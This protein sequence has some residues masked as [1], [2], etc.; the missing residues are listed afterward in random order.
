MSLKQILPFL[1]GFLFLSACS[2][3]NSRPIREA[4][5]A[6]L[7]DKHEIVS[8]GSLDYQSILN[9]AEYSKIPKVG[10]LIKERLGD[11][12]Q[13]SSPIYFAV[14][15]P[16]DSNGNPGSTVI[17]LDVKNQDTLEER[18]A[19]SGLF[20]EQDGDLKF[21]LNDDL[22]IGMK[23]NLALVVIQ[24]GDYDGKAVLKSIFQATEGEVS[25]GKTDELLQQKADVSV[26]ANLENLYG[27]S[28]T[29]LRNLN[30]TKLNEI[31][32]LV[33][34]SY[35]HA[36]LNFERGRI[37]IS[38]KNLFSKTLQKRMFLKEDPM[39][40]IR[41]KFASGKVRVGVSANL[42]VAKLEKYLDDFAPEFKQNLIQS[43]TEYALAAMVLGDSPLT[44]I[45]SGT[46]G[47]VVL[48]E[49]QLGMGGFVPEISYMV[50]I[51][52][53]GRPLFET[54]AA[55]NSNGRMSVSVTDSEMKVHS[56]GVQA[57]SNQLVVPACGAN[58]GKKGITGFIDFQGL[59]IE[60]FG[61]PTAYKSLN[62]VQNITFT[63]T[64]EGAELVI[65]TTNPKE[66][67]LKQIIDLYTRDIEKMAGN[68]V[69]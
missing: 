53:S 42:D 63:M 68:L 43:K 6:F 40:T 15:G 46:A 12:L 7:K 13:P 26:I 51:G 4:F 24:G 19:S 17:F 29:S 33:K 48:G 52:K 54:W 27:T 58:F 69:L 5:S 45:F 25:G 8:F 32:K 60:S 3:S 18:L 61:L 67:I 62:V 22:T 64:N 44:K 34:D 47:L 20:I 16:F 49:P 37:V 39:A 1:I 2:S 55:A 9:K 59:D 14:S 50:G 28:N 56:S 38:S 21:S 23:N 41:T 65:N 35:V 31:Q 10:K 11:A 30:Q 66:N 57:V 36:Q